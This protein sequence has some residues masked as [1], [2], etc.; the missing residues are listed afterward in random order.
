MKHSI[1]VKAASEAK[2]RKAKCTDRRKRQCKYKTT[3]S[4]LSF[5]A[6]SCPVVKGM[7]CVSACESSLSKALHYS[8]PN[9]SS[10]RARC[11][12]TVS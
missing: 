10:S 11:L 7:H 12:F 3:P 9:S 2:V 1:R 6:H 4:E 8:D 5:K